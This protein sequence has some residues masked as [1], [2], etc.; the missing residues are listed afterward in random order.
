MDSIYDKIKFLVRYLNEC[1]KA[2]DEGHQKISDE[3]WDNKYFELQELEKETGLILSNSPTQSISYEVVNALKKVEHSHKMLSLE[4]TK[5]V[6]EVTSFVGKKDFLVMCKMD[7]LTCSLTYRNG[8]LVSAETRGNGLVGEDILHNARVLPSI[9]SKIPYMDELIIDGEII[10]TYT[11]FTK[12]SS[13][14]KN[15]R[16]FAAGSIRLLDSKECAS[17]NLTFVVWDVITPMMFDDGTEYKLSQKLNFLVPFGFTVVPYAT[18]PAYYA[19]DTEVEMDMF[20]EQVTQMAQGFS[21]PIDGAVI[22]FNDCAYGRSLGETT[23]H[24]KN[25]LAYKFYDETYWTR[26]LGIEWTMGRTSILTPVAIFKPI[27]IDGSTVERASLHN[28]SIMSDLFGPF[29]PYKSDEVEVFKANMII[30]QI[31]S[32]KNV[33]SYNEEYK[34]SIPK[35]C[36]ICSKETTVCNSGDSLFLMCTNPSCPGKLINRLDHFC[37]KK[38]LDMKGI[39]KATLEKLIDWGWVADFKDIFELSPH[40]N[41]WIQ[42]PGFG[43]KS[44]E[45][46]LNAINTGANCELHQFIAAL[47]IPLIGST[48]SKELAK[49]FE[50]WE[51]FI[52]AAEGGF[53]FYTLPNFGSEMHNSLVSFNYDEAKLLA[54]HYIHFNAPEVS[55]STFS[56]SDLTGKTF[57]IT[58]KVIYFK[59]RDEIKARIEALGGKVTGSVSRNTDFLINNDLNATTSK[60]MTAKL[61]G[62]PILS[63][64]DFIQTFGIE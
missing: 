25:A 9:P 14:Y 28:L 16:N 23:H 50:T 31:K 49:H 3:E 10:C 26:L 63:E 34:I 48:A 51:K 13:E 8:E 20:I 38:G 52:E 21:Y 22:K 64:S 7:G 53:A 36:P 24:F 11:D 1:T 54:D 19:D 4:K 62:I 6:D 5:S 30:P 40:K 18:G 47:G 37:G 17:R 39:S 41:E 35:E 46:I 45:K 44:V 2:Y 32:V 27:D 33:C 15:P 55:E 12:F 42:K 59:N 43:S 58:G 61:L 56:G 29:G 57:V 60:N